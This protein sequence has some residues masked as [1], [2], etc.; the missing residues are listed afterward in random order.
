M[1]PS[2]RS[3]VAGCSETWPRRTGSLRYMEFRERKLWTLEEV[4]FNSLAIQASLLP[5][6]TYRLIFTA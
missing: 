1:P 5:S 4:V 2:M 6:S 3:R